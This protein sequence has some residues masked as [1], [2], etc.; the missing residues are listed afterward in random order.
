MNELTKKLP[1]SFLQKLKKLYPGRYDAIARTFLEK[2]TTTFRVNYLN[3]DLV[4]LRRRLCHKHIRFNELAYPQGTF[5][6]KMPL[7]QFQNSDIYQRGLVSV[8]NISSMLAVIGLAPAAGEKILDLCAA[9]G[10]KTAHIASTA[11]TAEIVAVEKVRKRYYKLQA[12][13]RQQGADSVKTLLLDG[14]WVRKKYPDYFDKI[15]ADVPCSTEGKFLVSNP[16]SY[17]YWSERKVREMEH[18]Q[19]KLL[20]SAF[21]ALKQGGV[22]VYSTCTFSPEENEGVI[23]WF[24]NRFKKK[25]ELMPLAYPCKNAVDGLRRWKDEKFPAD[26]KYTKRIIP[27]SLFEGFFIAKI[28]KT[29]S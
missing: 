27:D 23:N 8:Q 20:H 19:R 29:S 1:N 12:Y 11:P 5:T 6:L 16:A 22:L 25:V 7:R 4:S 17:K 18:K 9:P 13:L 3:I 15:L 28:K 24:L 26:M 2:K 10:I 14:I 21:F